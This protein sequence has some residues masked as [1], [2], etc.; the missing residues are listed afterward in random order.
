LFCLRP[1]LQLQ[2]QLQVSANLKVRCDKVNRTLDTVG[3]T[4][5]GFLRLRDKYIEWQ[6]QAR[7]RVTA[8]GS[9]A[10]AANS[11]ASPNGK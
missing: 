7:A 4:H 11:S 1:Q 9:V 10:A 8:D 3:L 5:Q 2:L 6:A